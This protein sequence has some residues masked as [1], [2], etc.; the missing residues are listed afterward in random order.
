VG[1]NPPESLSCFVKSDGETEKVVKVH[2]FCGGHN[3]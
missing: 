3:F 1:L 2:S